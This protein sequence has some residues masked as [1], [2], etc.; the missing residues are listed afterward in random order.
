M[1]RS[2]LG[3]KLR[4]VGE[5][6]KAAKYAGI[7]ITRSIMI[8]MII[9]GGLIGIAGMGEIS[10]LFYFVQEGFS[11]GYGYT[12][13]PVALLARLNPWGVLPAAVIFGVLYSGG[14]AMKAVTGVP[15]ALTDV[16]QGL[17]LIFIL[18]SELLRRRK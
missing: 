3:Y 14:L 6:R 12:C 17:V 9:S 15:Q 2:V 10:G 11:P 8:S 13:I 5:N 4:V 18:I 1:S 7:N 16:I